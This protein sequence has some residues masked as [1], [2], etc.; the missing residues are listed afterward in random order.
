MA[1]PSPAKL[2]EMGASRKG[3]PPPFFLTPAILAPCLAPKQVP[4]AHLAAEPL[5]DLDQG[6]EKRKEGSEDWER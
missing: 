1:A 4:R 3:H 5:V 2:R 6:V